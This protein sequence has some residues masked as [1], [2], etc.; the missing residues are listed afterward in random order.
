MAVV[1]SFWQSGRGKRAIF[2][3]GF[4][5]TTHVSKVTYMSKHSSGLSLQVNQSCRFSCSLSLYEWGFI[6]V[7]QILHFW[8]SFV[9][10]TVVDSDSSLLIKLPLHH[11]LPAGTAPKPIDCSRRMAPWHRVLDRALDDF[12]LE[13]CI[14]RSCL[15]YLELKSLLRWNGI[16]R[17]TGL[18]LGQRCI[19]STVMPPVTLSQVSWKI[20]WHEFQRDH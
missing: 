19:L 4:Y 20:N 18:K 5:W 17:S 1:C 10:Q 11:E 14:L 16:L 12:L 9:E 8:D 6:S 3:A 2:Q 15:F 7:T 13:I